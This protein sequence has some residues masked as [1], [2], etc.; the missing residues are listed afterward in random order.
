MKK[1][2]ILLATLLCAVA[3]NVTAQQIVPS[4]TG[5]DFWMAF[6]PNMASNSV[7]SLMIASEEDCTVHIENSSHTW[8]IT[9][10][11]EAN[12]MVQVPVPDNIGGGAS[13][14]GNYLP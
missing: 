8:D 12:L 11:I 7:R 3:G 4:L 6:L 2:I 10:A 5:T 9:V 14:K 13:F 1:T